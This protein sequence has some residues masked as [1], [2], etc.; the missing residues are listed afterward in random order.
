MPIKVTIEGLAVGSNESE[1]AGPMESR[2]E[3]RGH[4]DR[5][6]SETL[7]ICLEQHV[8]TERDDC[9]GR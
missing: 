7:L 6:I 8:S 3:V 4:L 1:F 2:S 5:A 9:R